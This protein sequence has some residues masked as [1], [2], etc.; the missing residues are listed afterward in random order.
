MADQLNSDYPRRMDTIR[1]PINVTLHSSTQGQGTERLPINLPLLSIPHQQKD[2][3]PIQIVNE[4]IQFHY[5]QRPTEEGAEAAKLLPVLLVGPTSTDQIIARLV[6]NRL[7]QQQKTILIAQAA[8][9]EQPR[10]WEEVIGVQ[11]SDTM[12]GSLVR[13]DRA[14]WDALQDVFDAFSLTLIERWSPFTVVVLAAG[15]SSRMGRAKQLVPVLG[16]P[17]VNRAVETALESGAHRILLITGAYADQVEQTLEGAKLS[18]N[19][20]L[21]VVHNPAWKEGQSSSMRSA[22]RW[23]MDE[24]NMDESWRLFSPIIFMPVDQPYL[25]S[26]VLRRLFRQWRDGAQLVA[27]AVYGN[28][29]GAPAL[30]DSAFWPEML[31]VHGDVGGKIILRQN[32]DKLVTISVPLEQL[33]DMDSP[34]DL[35]TNDR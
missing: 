28:A 12:S 9:Q 23:I 18:P 17:M 35:P 15:Q 4:L 32:Q 19:P 10:R 20:R 25:R 24:A 2:G 22:I 3:S 21:T 16:V 30:F 14:E 33:M 1:N 26:T 13:S 5:R 7:I 6:A 11:Q 29:R 31:Q 34:D 8:D 27:P